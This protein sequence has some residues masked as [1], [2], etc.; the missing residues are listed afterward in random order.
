MTCIVGVAHEG[1]VYI[2]G[3][4]AGSNGWSMVD[5]SDP[6]VFVNGPFVF[7]FTTS[8][9]MGQLLRYSLTPPK[10]HPDTDVMAFM[11]NDF[12]SAVRA[13]LKDGGFASKQNETE[14]GGEFLVGYAGR[15]FKIEGDYQVGESADGY[16]SCGCGESYAL[17][18]LY[19]TKGAPV[20][21]R[22]ET[23]L[24]AA[25][26]HSSGVRAPYRILSA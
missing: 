12:I 2:G 18:S 13:C 23:A 4:S 14:R 5:R 11:V 7:G 6:K 26:A 17:G 20:V 8:F 16:D 10:H 22:I 25:E 1:K 19:A 3:D 21:E 9:R 24:R 15:L